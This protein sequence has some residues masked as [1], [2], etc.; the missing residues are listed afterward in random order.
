MKTGK[1]AFAASILATVLVVSTLMLLGVLLVIELW[2]FDF[3][4][5]YLYQRE[6]QARA[7]VESG[8]LLYEKDSTLY[9]RRADDGSVLLFEGDESSRVYYKRERWGMYEVV[10][11]RNGK[12][13]SIRL[14]GKSAESRYGATLYIPENGQAFSL[15][16]RTFVEGDVYL[17]QNGISYTQV[18]SEFFKGKALK[19][20]QIKTSGEDLPVLDAESWEVAEVLHS[21]VGERDWL[22]NGSVLESAFFDE[23]VL[24]ADVGEYLSGVRVKGRVVLYASGTLFVERDVRLDGVILVAQQVE[25]A[26]DFSGCV[27]VFA[28]DTILLGNRVCL[29]AGSGLH[30]WREGEKGGFVRL[31]E[32]C[33]VNGYVI[34]KAD[35][36]D[37]ERKRAVYVQPESSRVRGLVFVDGIA[38]VHG[39]VTGSLYA[40]GCYYFA[41]EGYY[42]GILHNAVL[43][44]NPGLVYPLLLEGPYER[45]TVRWLD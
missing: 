13:E 36:D 31:G 9:S 6:E 37:G 4:R 8:F 45:R 15:T 17:P 18:R 28:R 11:V 23:P 22:E 2:N 21:G 40:R 44:G 42:S 1:H 43:P 20:E 35:A 3:T 16:G 30:L 27:Q 29:K 14:V 33:E 12:R 26:D 38:E 34:V 5:Y 7:N 39:T 19:K 41:P 10:S 24:R 32:H 25:F